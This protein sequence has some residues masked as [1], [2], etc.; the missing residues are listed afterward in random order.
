MTKV[1][2]VL[3]AS[4]LFGTALFAGAQDAV[5]VQ[6]PF[7]FHVSGKTLTAG[8]YNVTRVFDREP[9]LLRISGTQGQEPVAFLAGLAS[10][11]QIGAGLSFHRYGDSYYLS[12]ITTASGK[13]S[14]PR[15]RA[16]RLAAS[17]SYDGEVTVGSE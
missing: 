8:T 6:V 11:S 13:F 10:S 14:L 9:G 16:E 17:R 4:M 12:G 3:F 2:R 15:S 7:D 5:R 1:I